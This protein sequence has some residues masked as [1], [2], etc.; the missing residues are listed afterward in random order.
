MD[1]LHKR[2]LILNGNIKKA[3]ITLAVPIMF[4]NLIQTLYSLAD[5]FWVSKLG[6][7]EVAATGFVW[8]ILYLI[9][10]IGMG[11]TL[12][13]TSLI[14]QYVGSSDEKNATL[15]ASQIFSV[16]VI[17][18]AILTLFGYFV[19]PVIVNFMG[20]SEALYI[21]SCKYLSIMFFDIP[22]LFI[23]MIFGAIRQ[24][25]GD[26]ISPMIL[27]ILGAVTNLILDPILIF[28]FNMG[29]GGAA[30]AT[31][32]SKVIFVPFIVYIL[33]NNKNGISLSI[34]KIRLQKKI[35]SKILKVGIPT[36]VGQSASS[37]GFIVLNTFI[38]SY[39]NATMAA[40]NI[41]NNIN[42]I[43]L[44]P[45]LGIGNALASIVGQ[46]LGAGNIKRV[47]LAFK[48]S[49]YISTIILAIGGSILFLFSNN[50]IK[51]FITNSN[52]AVVLTEGAYYLK[53]ISATL[54]FMGI[55]QILLG[56][57]QGSG[58]TIYSMYMEMGRLWFLRLPLILLFKN[59]TNLGSPSVWYSM[60]LS[61]GLI[62][63]FGL[64]IYSSGKWNQN[65]IQS[66]LSS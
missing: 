63:I 44:M 60:V 22:S 56:V 5:M 49:I 37:L 51:I 40:F 52:D 30:L 34:S 59:F 33:F 7:V 38:V 15:V 9:I 14:S 8:P 50:I 57:F 58:H 46:N 39:G 66:K 13:G 43:V 21:N 27:N 23:F 16:T 2:E 28:K 62:C 11:V 47:K 31:V 64:I 32:L 35:V 42:S 4:N 18:G 24:A 41:G 19:T 1:Y 53:I 36:C 48:N 29:I 20:A 61:N 65:I 6:S 26:T 25:E 10:S 45:A 55:F 12:A 17:L 54:P 3:I